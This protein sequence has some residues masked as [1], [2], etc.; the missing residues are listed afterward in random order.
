M[1]AMEC[2]TCRYGLQE[3]GV[4]L[5]ANEDRLWSASP[6]EVAS[7]QVCHLWGSK[8]QVGLHSRA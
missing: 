8:E 1:E 5:C 4:T 6:E 7:Y 2:K 3:D